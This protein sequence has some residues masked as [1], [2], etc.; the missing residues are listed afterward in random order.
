MMRSGYVGVVL[1]GIAATVA[2][3]FESRLPVSDDVHFLLQLLWLAVAVAGL[4]IFM[5]Q[6]ALSQL[7]Q[8]SHQSHENILEWQD[9]DRLWLQ[10]HPDEEEV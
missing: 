1:V 2:L 7:Q 8:T 4:F 6:P 9:A 3:L 10:A 5:L